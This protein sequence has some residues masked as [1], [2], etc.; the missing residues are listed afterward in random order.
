VYLYNPIAKR[1]RAK[2]FE[3]NYQGSYMILGK[4]SP[5]IYKLQIEECKSI[6]VHVKRLKRVN[7]GPKVNRN[8]LETEK[9]RLSKKDQSLRQSEPRLNE[10]S[11]KSHIDA[12][13]LHTHSYNLRR[14]TRTS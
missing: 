5:L 2:K 12:D 4:I 8:T 3:H 1:G 14:P 6:V 10:I 9:P 11:E 7:T 13:M